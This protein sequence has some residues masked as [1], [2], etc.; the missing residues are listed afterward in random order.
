VYNE[1]QK[2]D[3]P[4]TKLYLLRSLADEGLC[5][6]VEARNKREALERAT[7]IKDGLVP[8][9]LDPTITV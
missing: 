5:L 6:I 7:D 8:L 9:T 3:S 2:P 1:P 4:K